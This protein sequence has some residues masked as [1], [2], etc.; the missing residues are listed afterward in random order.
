MTLDASACDLLFLKA[1]THSHWQDREVPDALLE[2]AW[3]LAKMG[4]TSANCLPLRMTFVKSPAAKALLKPCLAPGNVDKTMAAPVTAIC[5]FDLDFPE[6]LPRLFP[7]TDARSWFLGK[8]EL[9]EATARL[10]ASLQAAYFLMACRGLGLDL[11]PMGGFDAGKVDAAF[12]PGG[13]V[14]SFMLMNIGYG[15]PDKLYPRNPRLEF[16]DACKVV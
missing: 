1:R 7:Q 11:G 15:V 4:P 3:D 13:R 5:A 16:A 8:P 10:S 6:T 12:L 14:K 9:T 2:Q